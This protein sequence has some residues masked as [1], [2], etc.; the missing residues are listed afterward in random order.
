VTL[1]IVEAMREHEVLRVAVIDDGTTWCLISAEQLETV[2]LIYADALPQYHAELMDSYCH[3]MGSGGL[4]TVPDDGYIFQ[5]MSHH[6]IHGNRVNVMRQL[7]TEPIWI[8]AK[9]HAYGAASVVQDFRRY[10]GARPDD[11]DVK[12]ILQ[13]VML[14]IGCCM[15]NP[16]HAMLR[17]QMLARLMSV[18]RLPLLGE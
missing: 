5:H 2:Q 16:G 10:L 12:L 6:L 17:Q 7:L 11:S 14:C 13:A 9:L 4:Q 8:E 1:E 3:Q 18:A 15:E